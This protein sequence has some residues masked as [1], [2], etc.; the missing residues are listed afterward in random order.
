MRWSLS[1]FVLVCAIFSAAQQPGQQKVQD[2]IRV[3]SPVIALEHVRV[4][5]GTG[6]PAKADQTIVISEGKISSIVAFAT[7]SR[8]ARRR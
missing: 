7:P 6:A 5:D 2:F 3:Q 8:R 1:A 4:V